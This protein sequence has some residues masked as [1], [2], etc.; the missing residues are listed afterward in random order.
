MKAVIKISA[1]ALFNPLLNTAIGGKAIQLSETE[2]LD[3]WHKYLYTPVSSVYENL[4]ELRKKIKTSKKNIVVPEV[5][6]MSKAKRRGRAFAQPTKKQRMSKDIAAFE[7]KQAKQRKRLQDRE[8]KRKKELAKAKKNAKAQ[9]ER[10][11][12]KKTE[13]A[14]T[15]K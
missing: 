6:D 14:Q 10:E 8:E 4:G 12:K 9:A 5:L 3:N 1:L 11:N 7:A 15:P 2:V 13:K